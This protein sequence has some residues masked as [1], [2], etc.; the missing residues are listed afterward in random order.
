MIPLIVCSKSLACLITF[1]N[2][3]IPSSGTLF[4]AFADQR[5]SINVKVFFMFL[6]QALILGVAWWLN[7]TSSESDT[8]DDEVETSA[9]NSDIAT[10]LGYFVWIWGIVYGLIIHQYN[11]ILMQPLEG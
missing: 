1:L 8:N 2:V 7:P 10:M 4:A 3:V 9:D 5:K 11:N 6:I